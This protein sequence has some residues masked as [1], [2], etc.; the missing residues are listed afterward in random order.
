MKTYPV[1]V[2]IAI[3]AFAYTGTA[4]AAPSPV[5]V[6]SKV[7]AKLVEAFGDDAKTIRITYVD[8]NAILT[9]TVVERSTQE[10]AEQ[11][12]L[13]F[14]EVSS[15]DNQLRAEKDRNLMEGQLQDEGMDAALETEAKAALTGEIGQHAKDINVEAAGGVV[16]LRGTV[17]DE[18]R[19]KLALD[20]I[21]KLAHVEKA[22]DLL[23]VK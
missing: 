4:A 14:P 5:E 16:A 17:P 10:L 23:R 11:V 12:A 1:A 18:T 7:S 22:I 15:V 3:L 9:G 20:S 8:G 19:R 21:A 2:I 13:F 6:E